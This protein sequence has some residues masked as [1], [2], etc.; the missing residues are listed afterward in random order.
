MPVKIVPIAYAL[1]KLYFHFI[2]HRM[3][4]GCGDS[5]PLDFEPNGIPF[6][7]KSKGKL[8]PQPYPI[9][10]GRKWKYSFLSVYAQGK[11]LYLKRHAWCNP[12]ELTLFDEYIELSFW[13]S[14]CVNVSTRIGVQWLGETG[15]SA[16]NCARR[17]YRDGAIKCHA[18][19]LD[20]R[21]THRNLFKIWNQ[22][23]VRLVPNQ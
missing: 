20:D 11:I 2:S 23:D 16:G 6:G 14:L 13:K 18:L 19:T 21:R 1:R 5:F 7:S 3:G 15:H 8:S 10:C 4:Y 9:Q 17:R 12:S 22:T